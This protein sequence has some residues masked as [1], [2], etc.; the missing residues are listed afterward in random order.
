LL[1]LG[2][3][4]KGEAGL[5][6]VSGNEIVAADVR[7]SVRF[8]PQTV[9]SYRLCGHEPAN[10]SRSE[11][12]TQHFVAGQSATA[13]YELELQ[14][15]GDAEVATVVLEWRDAASGEA[16][17]ETRKVSVREFAASFRQAEESVQLA[18]LAVAAAEVL[19]QSPFAEP[20][21]SAEMLDLARAAQGEA[22]RPQEFARFVDLF[23]RI[24]SADDRQR[25]AGA[26]E[27][28]PAP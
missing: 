20:I 14:G 5:P 17:V 22:K 18:G 23:E 1:Q 9:I 13:V 6:D 3:K 7:M 16:K 8:N 11:T 4:A 15:D 12:P 21:L 19:R 2:V 24:L 10:L 25:R 28:G 26:Q 27:R